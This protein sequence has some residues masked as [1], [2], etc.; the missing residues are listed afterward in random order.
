MSGMR[1]DD[2]IF[3]TGHRGLVGSALVRRLEQGGYR[4][5]LKATHADLDLTD[6]GAVRR[7]FE[8]ER[9]THV[10]MAAARVGGIVANSTYPAEFIHEN[11]AIQ[12][13][14]IHH[15]WKSGV[16]KLLFLGSS[17]IYPKFAPQP[18]KEEHL[19]TGQLEPT[20][21]AYAIAKITGIKMCAA[22]NR[23][24][25]TNFLSAMPTNIYGPGDTYDLQ[26][27]HVVP[28]LIRKIHTAKLA[29]APEVEVWGSGTPLREFLF[30]DDLADACV[31]MME[32]LDV[33]D[34]GE[35]INVGAGAE[36]SIVDLTRL[37]G[38][39]IGFSGRIRL[40]KT[41]PDGMPRKLLDVSRLGALGWKARTPLR[42]GL[43]FAYKDF[44]AR[45]IA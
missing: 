35:F 20:N 23:Q 6:E 5:L 18:M 2:R 13:N 3:V 40:D 33:A 36:I 27:S 21:E 45:A 30:S 34:L 22:Y 1:I 15:A 26:N 39:V 43:A 44:L 37:V 7:F 41:K 12:N 10:M 16:T 14:V 9:P 38:E 42:E 4:N 8:S 32:R 17:C 28:A 11:L 19:L 24:Y 25:G 29:G 31:F